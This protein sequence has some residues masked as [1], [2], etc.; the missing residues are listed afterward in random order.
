VFI[1]RYKV[2]F[3]S[4]LACLCLFVTRGELLSQA[5]CTRICYSSALFISYANEGKGVEND[6]KS[7]WSMV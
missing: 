7:S 2:N 1:T 6:G 4:L 3:L 5:L